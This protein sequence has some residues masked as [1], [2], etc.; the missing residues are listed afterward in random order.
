MSSEFRFTY[1]DAEGNFCFLIPAPEYVNSQL[2]AGKT[3]EEIKAFLLERD[4]RPYAVDVINECHV[5][6]LPTDRYFRNA[7]DHDDKGKPTVHRGKAE[8]LHMNKLRAMR[9]DALAKLDM[10][11]MKALEAND[12]IKQKLI[13]NKKQ[14]LRDMPTNEDLSKHKTL[15]ELKNY[16]PPYLQELA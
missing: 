8:A 14:Q 2:Q 16:V 12:A 10:E 5:S 13:A 4:A 11:F 1:K 15:D 6:E 7:W 3:L 9:N